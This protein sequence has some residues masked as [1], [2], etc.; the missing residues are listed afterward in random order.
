MLGV[1]EL[2]ALE[3]SRPI[4]LPSRRRFPTVKT[5]DKFVDLRPSEWEAIKAKQR[6]RC[7]NCGVKA[8]LTREH[9]EPHVRGGPSMAHNIVGWCWPCNRTKKFTVKAG[10][11]ISLFSKTVTE[12]SVVLIRRRLCYRAVTG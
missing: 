8:K 12:W 2:R 4:P 6:Y 5:S 7:A 9:V 10:D 1:R 11:P 3:S